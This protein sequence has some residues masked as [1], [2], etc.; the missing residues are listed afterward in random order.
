MLFLSALC[1][2][3]PG[4]ALT[5]IPTENCPESMRQIQRIGFQRIYSSGTTKN[6]FVVASA[7]PAVLASWTALTTASD[8]T[9]VTLSPF[10][11]QPETEAGAPRE[12]GGGNATLG[13]VPIILGSE[14]TTFS[15]MLLQ[16]KQTIIKALKDYEC[17]Q[18]GVYLFDENGKIGAIADDNSNPTEWYPIPV[19][20]FFV[21]DKTLGGYEAPDSNTMQ[22]SFVPNWSLEFGIIDPTDFNPLTDL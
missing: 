7:D 1:S 12:Y 18:L 9:K 6:K 13:G 3:P 20:Q 15:C 22:F 17:E 11:N 14:P 5:D 19:Q 4:A 2:C 10:I 21:G 16:V 8:G